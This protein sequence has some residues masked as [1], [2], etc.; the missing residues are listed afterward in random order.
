[1]KFIRSKVKDKPMANPMLK[2]ITEAINKRLH[3][4]S[5]YLQRQSNSLSIKTRTVGFFS[6]CLL[7]GAVNLIVLLHGFS[8][9]K[10]SIVVT[11]ITFPAYAGKSNNDLR[12]D[13]NV[14]LREESEHIQAFKLYL[15]SLKGTKTGQL[16][17]DSIMI[18]RPHLLDSILLL[19]NMYQIQSLKR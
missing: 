14:I 18:P 15:D 5:D 12:N 3:H 16:L 6:F 8:G 17:F 19:E 7:F 2:K 11:P 9:N 13:G 1:M 4:L 10:S